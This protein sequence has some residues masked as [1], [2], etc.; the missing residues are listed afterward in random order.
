[1]RDG[2]PARA[3][4]AVLADPGQRAAHV[5]ALVALVESNGYAGI[6]L[7][8]EQ[9]AFADPLSTWAATRPN[10]VQ[11][12]AELGAQLHAR[13]RLLTVTTPPIYNGTRAPGSGYWVYDWAGIA[14][15]IDRLRIMTYEYSLASPGPMAPLPWVRDVLAF[16]I[17]QVHQAKVQVGIPAYGRNWVAGIAG[18][19]PDG[20]S[21]ERVDVR[22]ANVDALIAQKG[23]TPARDAWSGEMTFSYADTY[24]GAPPAGTP[25]PTVTCQVFRTVW[26]PDVAAMM[27]RAHLVGSFGLS[28]LAL[29]SLGFEDAS[30]WPPLRDYIGT[31]P[32][33]SGQDPVGAVESIVAGAGTVTVTGWGLDPETDLP[34]QAEMYTAGGMSLA[35]A[36]AQ[37]MDVAFSFPGAGPFHGLSATVAAP[38]GNQWICVVIRGVGAGV[39][40][41]G[42][43]CTNVTVA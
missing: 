41:K 2:L 21:P 4:A 25:G 33:P 29:W 10:W 20:V 40:A 13:G 42:V 39:A 6:D 5:N 35:V 43:N 30:F 37:R 16:A 8:Y 34:V 18:T 9:F 28:G 38:P 36:N 23:V 24:T 31:L 14:P 3:M 19:C 22:S 12:V 7:D 32:R 27:E 26:Y 11:F 15:H 17:T 1:V